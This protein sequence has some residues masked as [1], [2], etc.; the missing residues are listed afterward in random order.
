V[1]WI[2]RENAHVERVACP[3]LILRFIDADAQFDF[4]SPRTDPMTLDG[5]PF[6]MPGVRLGHR[7]GKCSFEAFLEEYALTEDPA[8]VLMGKIIRGADIP[9]EPDLAVES[10]GIRAVALGF[11][12]KYGLNDQDKIAAQLELYDALYLYC[13]IQTEEEADYTAI[14]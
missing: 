4:V 13:R 5:I 9:F 2:T 1:K 7:D 8:L 12:H 14:P 6:D 3:W 11:M 10:L